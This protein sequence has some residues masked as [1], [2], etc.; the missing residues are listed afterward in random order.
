MA[1]E[2]IQKQIRKERTRNYLARDFDSF[3]SELLKY[4]KAYFPDKISDFSEASMGGLFLDMNAFVGDT[5]SFYLDHQFNELNPNTAVETANIENHIR[6]SGIKIV[7]A[8]PAVVQVDIF[9]EVFAIDGPGGNPIPDP[10]LLPKVLAG[11]QLRSANGTQF[12]LVEDVDFTET[13]RA[14]NLKANVVRGVAGTG[15]R[16]GTFI[17]S[18][19]GLCVSGD[20]RTET[21][22]I[23]NTFVPFR[24]ISL[25][26][27][28]V[29]EVI[30]VRDSDGNV[31]YEV[32][33][34]TQSNVFRGIKNVNADGDIVDSTLEL[35]P[36]PYRYV[37]L[38]SLQSRAT[39]LRFGSGNADSLDDDI[40]P[41]PS[42]LALPLYGKTTFSRFAL[43]PNKLLD[44][45]SLGISP[46][47]TA[48]TVRYRH[49]GGRNHNVGPNAIRFVKRFQR[50]FPRSIDYNAANHPGIANNTFTNLSNRVANSVDVSNPVAAV[51]GDTAP[52]INDLRARVT[53]ARALQGRIVSKQDFLARVYS[54]P[55]KFG[56]VFRAAISPNPETPLSTL[57]YIISRDSAGRL[58]VATDT[59]KENL[60]LYLNEFRLI[61]DAVDI[62]DAQPINFRVRY[63]VLLDP[64][65]NK[66]GVISKINTAIGRALRVS[67]FQINQP[68][69]RDDLVN[70]IINQQGVLSMTE[71]EIIDVPTDGSGRFEGRQ[72]NRTSFSR[73]S[74]L[75]N[76]IYTGPVGS[77][78]E[79]RY[80]GADIIGSAV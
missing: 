24:T 27:P 71:L 60:S 50:E 58:T 75:K 7:G 30:S 31:Y 54:L 15:V 20:E 63:Q 1:K 59:L 17:V 3:R 42:E 66:S 39:T 14:G 70:I 40:V 73:E 69:V 11:T 72:Y 62:L 51:G 52:T 53:S 21:F 41:D 16:K 80:P 36:A 77:I 44:T 74:T 2:R 33:S 18:R 19:S 55:A 10:A 23:P 29:T 61:S 6:N 47:N 35:I 26:S 12:N 22:S 32:E 56:R 67:N 9:F 13:D 5:L 8:S 49:G 4:A 38:T 43:D 48:I 68:I 28:N 34:L 25:S 79:L 64:N 76:G 46:K 45:Q 57:V 78:F 37:S 65:Y